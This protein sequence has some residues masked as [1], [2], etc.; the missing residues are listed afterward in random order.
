LSFEFR[1]APAK[2]SEKPP[3]DINF[4]L[5]SDGNYTARNN[6]ADAEK[7]EVAELNAE[8]QMTPGEL[9]Y[10][11][12]ALESVNLPAMAGKIMNIGYGIGPDPNWQGTLRFDDNTEETEVQFS[13]LRSA[14]F[15][16]RTLV[17]NKLVTFVFDLKHITLNKV[18]EG[19]P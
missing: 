8:G 11:I 15:P 10:V 16:E 19:T 7:S 6:V 12:T 13:S 5:D 9:D 14:D 17:M 2:G 3:Y 4:S 1:E 18:S